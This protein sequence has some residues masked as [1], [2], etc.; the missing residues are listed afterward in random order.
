ML[1]TIQKALAFSPLLWLS[2]CQTSPTGRHQLM[3]TSDSQME[4][5]GKQAFDEMK[6]KEK[7]DHDPKVNTYVSCVAKAVTDVIEPKQS[8]EVVVFDDPQ[9]NA[10]ALPGGKI[11]VYSGLLKVAKNQDQLATVIGH[12]TGHVVAQH[13]RE[14]TSE[15][16]IAEGGLAAAGGVL[17]N[18]QDPKHQALMAALGVGAQVGV[19]LPFSRAQE[20]EADIIGLDTMARAGFRPAEAVALWHNMEAS[21]G[22]GPPAFLSDHPSDENRIKALQAK[23]PE[24]E[25]LAAA[26]GRAPKC[27]EP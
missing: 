23:L 16:L 2:A 26:N 15:Q 18:Q 5:M 6:Q 25:K 8:W 10:F 19:L 7:I 9:V 12:E 20:S 22:G 13:G 1:S 14:R 21:A 17:G 4:D 11:G 3:L 24:A 27:G